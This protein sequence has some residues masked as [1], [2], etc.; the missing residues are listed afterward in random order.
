MPE[1]K[2]NKEKVR[3]NTIQGI[4]LPDMF[5]DLQFTLMNKRYEELCGNDEQIRGIRTVV[6]DLGKQYEKLDLDQ[7]S[8]DLINRLL[9][10]KDDMNEHQRVIS[11]L[12]GQVDV[13]ELLFEKEAVCS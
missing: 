9:A 1:V 7:E 4:V 13:Y 6:E 5:K 3:V 11:Y 12:A 2:A 8:K 10:L